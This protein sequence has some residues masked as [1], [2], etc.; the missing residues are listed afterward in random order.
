MKREI[1]REA[2]VDSFLSYIVVFEVAL[3]QQLIFGISLLDEKKSIST[4]DHV[5]K[6]LRWGL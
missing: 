1:N 3:P 6:L 4:R 5:V 2:F